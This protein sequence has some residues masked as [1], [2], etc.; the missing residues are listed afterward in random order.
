MQGS[1]G[2]WFVVFKSWTFSYIY[3]WDFAISDLVVNCNS[4]IHHREHAY[5]K[6]L[7]WGWWWIQRK[8]FCGDQLEGANAAHRS[9]SLTPAPLCGCLLW[10]HSQLTQSTS[11]GLWL[12][13]CISGLK[14][15][16]CATTPYLRRDVFFHLAKIRFKSLQAI[17]GI[18]WKWSNSESLGIFMKSRLFLHNSFL[19]PEFLFRKYPE[20]CFWCLSLWKCL[21]LTVLDECIVYFYDIVM[22]RCIAIGYH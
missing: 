15:C 21:V 3:K 18:F 14:L 7:D 22:E 2:G 9:H 11:A 8:V 19:H 4:F 5:Q 1:L 17:E 20:S 10:A 16:T 12:T 6:F 13:W